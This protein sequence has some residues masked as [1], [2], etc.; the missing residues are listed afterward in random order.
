MALE[1]LNNYDKAIIN[2][3]FSLVIYSCFLKYIKELPYLGLARK[4]QRYHPGS[5][6]AKSWDSNFENPK[7]YYFII[8]SQAEGYVGWKYLFLTAFYL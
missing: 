7:V 2:N 3:L 1:H 8:Y 4:E 5:P 6:P